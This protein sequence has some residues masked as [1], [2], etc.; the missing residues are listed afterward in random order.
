MRV[1]NRWPLSRSS[2]T[3]PR[4]FCAMARF[5]MLLALASTAAALSTGGIRAG[6]AAHT[7]PSRSRLPSISSFMQDESPST[8][9]APVGAETAPPPSSGRSPALATGI[10]GTVVPTRAFAEQTAPPRPP[11][12]AAGV[13]DRL[14]A[15][16]PQSR[17]KTTTTVTEQC[18]ESSRDEWRGPCRS[19]R[20]TGAAPPMGSRQNSARRGALHRHRARE[21]NKGR[22]SFS[23]VRSTES[24]ESTMRST[25]SLRWSTQ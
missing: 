20:R 25:A 4:T 10:V 14:A 6:R 19:R 1:C 17:A 16:L 13:A 5:A 21:P 2:R 3:G 11:P 24:T 22:Y 8:E 15:Q 9:A 12:S 18:T 7:R 23:T